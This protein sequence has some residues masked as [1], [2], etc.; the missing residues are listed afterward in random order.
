M[1]YSLSEIE[2]KHHSIFC[3]PEYAKSKEYQEFWDFLRAGRFHTGEIKRRNKRGDD[4]WLAASYNPLRDELGA[5]KKV[6][7]VAVDITK[8]KTA[9]LMSETVLSEANEVMSKFAQGDLSQRMEG[10]YSGDFRQLK[11]AINSCSLKLTDV[12]ARITESANSVTRGAQEIAQGNSNLSARTEQQAGSLEQTA[13]SMEEMTSTVKQNSDNAQQANQL[14]VSARDQAE[15]GGSVV[16]DAVTAMSAIS[17]S[18]KQIAD[19]IG[20]INEIAFQ[21]NL[22]ALNASVEAARAGEQGRGFAVV[23]SEVRN[24]AGR[25]ATAAKEIKELIEDSV[26]KVDEGTR[27]VDESGNTLQ[28][29][30]VA[31]KK[32]TD[33]V[34]EI[35]AASKEQSTGIEQVN[36]AIMQMD[37]MTQQNTALVEEAAAASAAMGDEATQLTQLVSYFSS[38]DASGISG[39]GA[40]APATPDYHGTERRSADRPWSA[41]QDSTAAI[42]DSTAAPAKTGTE[43]GDWEEF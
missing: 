40:P 25:S 28:E 31:V 2:G 24:L 3:D 38:S 36:R 34:G 21:T 42:T 22:L 9:Q 39:L 30:V 12:M 15:K 37:E 13:S 35:A 20:V 23:A 41:Q 18:S 14:A 7:K 26:A 27:L 16:G 17:E 4:V 11:E 33:I 19:I 32:V 1:G 8:M 5:V 10:E 29:I 6:M 43:D